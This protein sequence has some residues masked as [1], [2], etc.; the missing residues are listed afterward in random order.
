VELALGWQ[1]AKWPLAGAG[2]AAEACKERQSAIATTVKLILMQ[3]RD[4][5]FMTTGALETENLNELDAFGK[6]N[7]EAKL[8]LSEKLLPQAE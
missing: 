6:S 7:L 3:C 4:G 5:N 1:M 2:Q 8:L